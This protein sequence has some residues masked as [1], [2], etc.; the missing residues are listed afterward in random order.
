MPPLGFI[1][2]CE[3]FD[4]YTEWAKAQCL[5]NATASVSRY[6]AGLISIRPDQDGQRRV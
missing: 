5:A 6:A 1:Q 2:L 3:R 4:I